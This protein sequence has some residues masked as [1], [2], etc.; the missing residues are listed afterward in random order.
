MTGTCDDIGAV[1][2]PHEGGGATKRRTVLAALAAVLPVPLARAQSTGKVYRIGVLLT[3]SRTFPATVHLVQAFYEGMRERGYVEGKNLVIEWR[4]AEAKLERLPAL[5]AEL[6]ALKPD[7]LV[8]G[9]GPAAVALK[10]TTSTIPIVFVQAA[11]P[12]GTG[13]VKT[14]ARP[15]GNVTGFSNLTDAIVGKQ[16]ELLREVTQQIRRVAVIHVVGD[17]TSSLQLSVMRKVAWPELQISVHEVKGPAD[18]DA[19][20][21][22]IAQERPDALHVFFNSTTYV[23]QQRIIDFAAAQ[24]LLAVYGEPI[25]VQSGGLMSYSHSAADLYRRSTVYV[26]RI[27]KGAKPADLPVQEPTKIDLAV[28]LRTAKALG[29]TIP[30]SVLFRADRVVE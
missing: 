16:L 9:A 23:H 24:R 8:A 28:N 5:A 27:L 29:I 30:K 1:I 21:R 12:V 6:V 19:A 4:G 7:L 18:F 17:P 26:D 20:F 25:F 10:K 3:T 14:L 13:L 15:G 11:D 2:L 22:A